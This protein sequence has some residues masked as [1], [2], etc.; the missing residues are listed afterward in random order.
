MEF[1]FDLSDYLSEEERKEIVR[2]VFKDAVQRELEYETNVERILSN[3]SYEIVFKAIEEIIPNYKEKITRGVE[4]CINDVNYSY[5]TFYKDS[6]SKYKTLG[7]TYIEE[8]V[9]KNKENIVAKVEKQINNCD[10]KE[11]V[12]KAFQDNMDNIVEKVYNVADCLSRLNNC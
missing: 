2:E 11:L 10:V 3:I 12:Q 8:T 9:T 1:K 6:Y 5:Y 7:Y 4:K